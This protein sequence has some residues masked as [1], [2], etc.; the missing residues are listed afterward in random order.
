MKRGRS[1]I[2]LCMEG[3]CYLGVLAFILLGAL[4]RDLNLLLVVAAM[5]VGPLVLSWRLVSATLRR[6]EI[7]RRLPEGVSSGD[8]LVVDITV[9]NL[10]R[11]LPSWAIMVTDR[12]QR[13]GDAQ[14][15]SQVTVM[16][17]YLPPGGTGEA[18]YRGRLTRRGHYQF[19]PLSI[20]SRIP[21][22]LLRCT[23]AIPN[24]ARIVVVPRLGQLTRQWHQQMQPDRMGA[25]QSM[26][27]QGWLEGDFYGMR[28]WRS[29]DSLRWIHWRTSARRNHLVV[30]QFE[31]H[32]RQSLALFLDLGSQPA[33][34]HQQSALVEMAVSFTA[35]LVAQQCRRGS[36]QLLLA[37]GGQRLEIVE[38]TSSMVLLREI[39]ERLAQVEADRAD[40]LAELLD[41]A[42]GRVPP[43]S[44]TVLISTRPVNLQDTDRFALVW[45][46]PFKRSRLRTL[47]CANVASAEFSTWFELPLD[48][49]QVNP[50]E[51]RTTV[52]D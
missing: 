30:R 10:R 35:T 48:D 24:L 3:F 37:V 39:M 16:L 42:L 5:M 49:R 18:S 25:Q 4:M 26:H 33:S 2:A 38:G 47:L 22:G 32:R 12:L 28:D 43:T 34:S 9:K 20:S 13:V 7:D 52:A 46:D 21:F 44:K 27:R 29:G 40:R 36:S 51:S 31:Q 15:R 14:D 11:W 6:L 17:P 19:G 45:D 8:L 23:V 1:Q 50:H 41:S